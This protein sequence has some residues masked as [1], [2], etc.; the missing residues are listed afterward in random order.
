MSEPAPNTVS[1]VSA[2]S[3]ACGRADDGEPELDVRAIPHDPQPLLAQIA[4]REPGAIEV[5]YLAR[6]SEVW[7]AQ[8]H[9]SG[10]SWSARHERLRP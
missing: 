2:R 1:D 4:D 8:A 6:G 5:T 10:L 3:C 9:A 7:V